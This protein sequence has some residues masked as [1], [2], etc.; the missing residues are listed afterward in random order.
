[1][2]T[3]LRLLH[4]NIGHRKL[5]SKKKTGGGARTYMLLRQASKL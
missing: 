4:F 2:Y 5:I 1:M 3:E